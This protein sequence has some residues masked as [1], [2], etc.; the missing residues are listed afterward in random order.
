MR[1]LTLA[2]ISGGL[3]ALTGCATTEK[4]VAYDPPLVVED[5]AANY[6]FPEEGF[7]LL[8]DASTGRFAT[9]LAISR[10]STRQ[11]PFGCDVM[12][13]ECGLSPREQAYWV[14][15]FRGAQKVRSLVFLSPTTLQVAAPGKSARCITA[16][17][18]GAKLLLEYVPTRLGPNSAE[19]MGVIYDA[20][21]AE[22]VATLRASRVIVGT[23]G[24][25]VPPGELADEQDADDVRPYDAYYQASRAFEQSAYDAVAQLIQLDEPLPQKERHRWGVRM[26]SAATAAH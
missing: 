17:A 2:L 25:E 9:A 18:L 1:T 7:R 8:A 15:T 10:Y 12:V 14:S 16:D 24:Y 11:D 3:L 4:P 21:T 23:A 22:P 5:F 19:I 20:K 13:H 6:D 26:P